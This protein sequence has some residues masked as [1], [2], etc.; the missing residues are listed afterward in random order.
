MIHGGIGE[1]YHQNFH[2]L[3]VHGL[4]RKMPKEKD[5]MM[6]Q[7]QLLCQALHGT[8]SSLTPRLY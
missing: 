2:T 8:N 4:K 7:G 6:V 1:E 5:T 3:S